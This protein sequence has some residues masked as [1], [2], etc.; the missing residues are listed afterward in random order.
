MTQELNERLAE[1]VGWYRS[2]STRGEWRNREGWWRDLPNYENSIDAQMRDL[3]P[4][5]EKK[6]WPITQHHAI[7]WEGPKEWEYLLQTGKPRPNM[8]NWPAGLVAHYV[9]EG[10]AFVGTGPT[11][12]AARAAAIDAAL[13]EP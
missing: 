4:L 7:F 6:W 10:R 13:G 5:V 2:E 9:P 3:D 12:A 1:K 8:T 11:P